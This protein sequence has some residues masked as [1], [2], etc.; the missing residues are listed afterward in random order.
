MFWTVALSSCSK[1]S[2]PGAERPLRR[3]FQGV[4]FAFCCL[5]SLLPRPQAA[6]IYWCVLQG[7]LGRLSHAQL[8]GGEAAAAANFPSGTGFL[9]GFPL[10]LFVPQTGTPPNWDSPSYNRVSANLAAYGR[11]PEIGLR[12][13]QL[14]LS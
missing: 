1:H 10:D 12:S 8:S 4:G 9:Q 5:V 3:V 11:S 2:S 14:D 6:Q 13:D 7:Y